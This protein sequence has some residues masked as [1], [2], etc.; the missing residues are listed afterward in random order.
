M[1]MR[2]LLWMESVSLLR[3]GAQLFT[4]DHLFVGPNDLALSM[5][6]Y[7]PA[8]WEEPEFLGA[9]EKVVDAAHRNGKTVGILAANGDKARTLLEQFDFVV[10]GGDVKALAFWFA[11][12]LGKTGLHG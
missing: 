12:E 11:Q 2:S 3:I 1:W 10:I 5:L 6:G 8:T 7:T 9:L 4:I